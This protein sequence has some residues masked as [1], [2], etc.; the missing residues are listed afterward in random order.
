MVTNINS[1]SI[2][3]LLNVIAMLL[4]MGISINYIF[5]VYSNLFLVLRYKEKTEA[6]ATYTYKIDSADSNEPSSYFTSI[7]FKANGKLYYETVSKKINENEYV[8]ILYC[9]K[10]PHKFIVADGYSTLVEILVSLFAFY[11]LYLI[12]STLLN[13]FT[14]I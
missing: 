6:R 11:A 4:T 3:K 1:D 13:M 8:P 14:N 5:I 2:A 9:R 10:N 7:E 12:A